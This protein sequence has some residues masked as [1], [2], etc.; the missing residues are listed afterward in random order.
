MCVLP[1]IILSMIVV[2][3]KNHTGF[4]EIAKKWDRKFP[5]HKG[6]FKRKNVTKGSRLSCSLQKWCVVSFHFLNCILYYSPHKFM[7]DCLF[8]HRKECI[9]HGSV[10]ATLS[11]LRPRCFPKGMEFRL[12]MLSIKPKRNKTH[13]PSC[14]PHR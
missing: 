7:I 9:R 4:S 2:T 6:K 10:K 14:I 1:T 11:R 5:E 3:G 8:M 13:V 12:E